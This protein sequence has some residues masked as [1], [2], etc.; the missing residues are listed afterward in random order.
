MGYKTSILSIGIVMV[1]SGFAL[2]YDLKEYY[3]LDQS[4][5]WTYLVNE[6]NNFH[7]ITC[8]IEGTEI[9][10]GVEAI[11]MGYSD[12]YREY[13]A[14]DAEGL[15]KYKD[16]SEDEYW[17]YVPPKLILPNINVGQTQKISGNIII[18]DTKGNKL[19]ENK[20]DE[21]VTLTSVEDVEVPAGKFTNCLKVSLVY[22]WQEIN[23]HRHGIENI[24][25][26]FARGVGKVKSFRTQV[27]YDIKT[28]EEDISNETE[29]LI[30]LVVNEVK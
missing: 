27:E 16:F 5:S 22:I 28:K 4:N 12:G 23:M 29:E 25:I 2:A 8:A 1:F 3:P 19:T 13:L 18:N 30:L 6:N 11:K 17:I 15:K 24:T 21:F 14:I 20:R 10:G 7:R 26:W 9:I